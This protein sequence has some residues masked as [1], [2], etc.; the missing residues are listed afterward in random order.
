MVLPLSLLKSSQNQT[1]LIE[2]KNGDSYIG[3]LAGCD[4]W[5]NIHLKDATF[6]S[7]DGDKFIKVP[8]IFIRGPTIKLMR[9]PEEVMMAVNDE[10]VEV[11]RQQ[12]QSQQNRFRR[13]QNQNRSNNYSGSNYN[14][15]GG[16]TNNSRWNQNPNNQQSNQQRQRCYYPSRPGGHGVYNGPPGGYSNRQDNRGNRDPR[17]NRDMRDNR[18]YRDS[19]GQP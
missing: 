16:N 13:P 14:R 7:K 18:D 5:M 11:R 10:V 3:K 1:M 19:R 2:L 17:D 4:S 6:T 8:E 12:Q 9:I 15:G